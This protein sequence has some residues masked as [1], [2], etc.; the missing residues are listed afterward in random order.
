MDRL[1]KRFFSTFRVLKKAYVCGFDQ[2]E[3]STIMDL[4]KHT[5]MAH[6]L[7]DYSPPFA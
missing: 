3:F 2:Q 1:A 6:H 5:C 7:P 4:K